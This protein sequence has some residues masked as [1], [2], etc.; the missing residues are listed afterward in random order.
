MADG[1][2][3]H[4]LDG[5][6]SAGGV[7]ATLRF[8]AAE[9]LLGATPEAMADLGLQELVLRVDGGPG[10]EKAVVTYRC[11][12]EHRRCLVWLPGRNDMFSHPHMVDQRLVLAPNLGPRKLYR[13]G[14]EDFV[15]HGDT[16][17]VMINSAAYDMSLVR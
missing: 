13:H 11:R 1:E 12:A 7:T 8:E 17:A 4:A 16:L 6:L 3:R 10:A 5:I 9:T 14:L 15:C 2:V